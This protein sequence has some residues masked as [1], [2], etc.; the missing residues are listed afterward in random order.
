MLLLQISQM[1]DFSNFFMRSL[2]KST[3]HTFFNVTVKNQTLIKKNSGI[4]L[5]AYAS[6]PVEQDIYCNFG[7]KTPA[8]EVNFQPVLWVLH[9]NNNFCG[10]GS[11]YLSY[12]LPLGS[13]SQ[14]K[15]YLTHYIQTELPN[16]L[17][18]F[19]MKSTWFY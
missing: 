4:F 2:V 7:H 6:I 8:A 5:I 11:R 16:I 1:H 9:F 14:N 19:I 18:P 10:I 3:R 15:L 13:R 17:Q 12:I